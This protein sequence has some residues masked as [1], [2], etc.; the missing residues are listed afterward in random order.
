MPFFSLYP[1]LSQALAQAAFKVRFRRNQLWSFGG[2]LLSAANCATFDPL[3][4]S[5]SSGLAANSDL[6][7]LKNT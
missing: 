6:Q 1:Q 4:S 2:W 3:L 7:V 5:T